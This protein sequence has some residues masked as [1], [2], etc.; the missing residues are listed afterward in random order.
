[1]ACQQIERMFSYRKIISQDIF[2]NISRFQIMIICQFIGTDRGQR[3]SFS[4]VSYII[5]RIESSHIIHIIFISQAWTELQSF[6]DVNLTKEFTIKTIM[7]VILIS[8]IQS[9]NR[10]FEYG[11]G[12]I[13]ISIQES[14]M[15]VRIAYRNSRTGKP[16]KVAHQTFAGNTGRRLINVL[17]ASRKIQS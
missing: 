12:N 8:H 17:A 4:I 13:G 15:S 3:I 7:L 6:H 11:L 16:S 10:I 14:I 1:M 9:F 5:L 2:I